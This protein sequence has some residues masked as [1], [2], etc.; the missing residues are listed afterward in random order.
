MQHAHESAADSEMERA[1]QE[2]S[3]LPAGT[4]KFVTRLP[5]R[6]SE[7]LEY[8]LFAGAASETLIFKRL[9]S[10]PADHLLTEFHNLNKIQSRLGLFLGQTVPQPIFVSS[11]MGLLVMKKLRGTP[12]TVILKRY[13]NHL[14]GRMC[15]SRVY[16][17]ARQAGSWLKSFQHLTKTEPLVYN[18]DTY[19]SNLKR[20]LMVCLEKGLQRPVAQEVL[21]RAALRSI[22]LNGMCIPAAARHGDFIPQNILLKDGCIAVVDFERFCERA[23]VYEDLGSFLGYLI[24]LSNLTYRRQSLR[25]SCEG[26]LRGYGQPLHEALL[27]LYTLVAALRIFADG[28]CREERGFFSSTTQV[29]SRRLRQLIA[30]RVLLTDFSYQ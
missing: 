18:S 28:P 14:I 6:H 2:H 3:F 24:T 26:F 5:A 19:L 12:M 9:L 25:I 29:L 7:L 30:G 17:A 21:G 8:R 1:L 22:P 11:D 27:N 15:I 13:A 20:W 16:D 23:A 10:G 4:L